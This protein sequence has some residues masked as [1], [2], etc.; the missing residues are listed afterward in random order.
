ML[1][2][3]TET[4]LA[5]AIRGASGPLSIKGGGTRGRAGQGEVLSLAALT[6]VELYEPGAMTLVARAGTPLAEVEALLAAEGQRLAFEPMDHRALLGT[7]GA[8]TVGGMV[9][10]NIS[11][12]R[13]VQ[14]GAC[15][16]ATLGLRFVD[17]AGTLVKNGGRVMKN[18][19]G[20]DLVKLLS[21]AH[22]TL[23]VISEVSLKVMPTPARSATLVWDGLDDA[24]TLDVFQRALGSPYDVTGAARLPGGE[25]P[26]RTLVRVEGLPDSVA[27]RAGRL[28]EGM[29]AGAPTRHMDDAEEQAEIWCAVRDALPF[30]GRAGDVWRVSTRASDMI[31]VCALGFETLLDWGGGLCWVLTPAGHDLR[32]DLDVQGHAALVRAAPETMARLGAF[33]P[34]SAPV[35]ALSAGL[36]AKFDPRGILNPGLMS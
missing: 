14:A 13:R 21:G 31:A 10:A 16:D 24:A 9:A 8:P 2:P 1:S 19:T 35:A 26:S 30:A 17:G 34:E 15:R 12:P 32:A 6:G 22:G 36:R 11:G 33:P 28:P 23:G 25:G 3:E 7:E 20:Y 18:V 4:E 5:D 27:Y 29:A